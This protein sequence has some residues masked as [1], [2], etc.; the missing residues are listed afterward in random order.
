MRHLKPPAEVVPRREFVDRLAKPIEERDPHFLVSRTTAPS[1]MRPSVSGSKC[2]WRRRA[3][4]QS[5]RFAIQ[6][7][8]GR[9]HHDAGVGTAVGC[10]KGHAGRGQ[11][12]Q[13]VNVTEH[14]A[15]VVQKHDFP[16]HAEAEHGKL[17]KGASVVRGGPG[18]RCDVVRCGQHARAERFQPCLRVVFSSPTDSRVNGQGRL[19]VCE[20]AQEAREQRR[21]SSVLVA[22]LCSSMAPTRGRVAQRSDDRGAAWPGVRMRMCSRNLAPSV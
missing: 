19:H 18:R 10:V 14:L 3:S 8:L 21:A 22:A 7:L 17:G 4:N 5:K 20:A 11:A 12:C 9:K 2:C 6:A 13:M 16:E 1:Q 15:V